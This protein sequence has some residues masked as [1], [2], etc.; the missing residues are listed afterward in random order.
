MPHSSQL[1][2]GTSTSSATQRLPPLQTLISNLRLQESN[3]EM[4]QTTGSLS[5]TELLPE[6]RT[7]V[8]RLASGLPPRDAELARTLVSLL[9]H[10]HRLSLLSPLIPS[11]SL[12]RTASWSSGPDSTTTS[13]SQS[14]PYSTLRRQV[15]DFKLERSWSQTQVASA[16]N[17]G[18]AT[19]LEATLLWSLIDDELEA[20]LSL[21]RS[22]IQVVDPFL[23]HL[24]PDYDAAEYDLDSLP[25]YEAAGFSDVDLNRKSSHK[26]RLDSGASR[27]TDNTSEK[28]KMDLEAVTLA[29][30]RLYLVAPQLHNQRV[31]LKKSKLEEMEK[32][33]SK[34]KQRHLDGEMQMRELDR[35]VELIGKASE[36]KF[37]DQVVC[38]DGEAMQQKMA[39]AK[40]KDMEKVRVHSCRWSPWAS[41]LGR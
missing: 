34:G 24:P 27:L 17:N 8:D 30:D 33:K 25:G 21:C 1:A 40:Q 39:R 10:F 20:V 16:S 2:P 28:M 35:M 12:P 23:D 38:I 13:K 9:S 14:D 22:H 29:I 3:G 7:R 5:D 18:A 41:F 31:E 26:D 4:A 32:A 11:T 37:T 15:S 36:R 6:L 19:S